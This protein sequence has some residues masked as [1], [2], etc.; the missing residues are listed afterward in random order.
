MT[1]VYFSRAMFAVLLLGFSSG[2]PL[3]L[4]T[5]TLQAW[6][7]EAGCDLT[8]IGL[9]TL[10]GLPYSIKVLWAPLLDRWG[11]ARLGRR[12]TWMLATQAGLVLG[13]L[14]MSRWTPS[15]PLLLLAC[16]ALFVALCSATQD[17]AL[18]AW[19]IDVLAPAELG[20]GASLAILG[21][22]CAVLT[23]FAGALR[24]AEM[25]SWNQVYALMA[26]A[27][28]VGFAATWLA[29][30]RREPDTRPTTLV[31][32]IWLPL[33]DFARRFGWR[34]GAIAAFVVLY[35]WGD[36]LAGNMSTSFL[37]EHGYK[38]GDIGD[39]QGGLGLAA[40][41][42][43]TLLGGWAFSRWSLA[44]CLWSFGLLQAA[45][46]LAYW[47][48]ALVPATWNGLAA[49]VTVENL[50]AGLGTAAFVGFLMALCDRRSSAV[51]Y[52]LLS[53]LMAA[54]RDL[55]AAPAGWVA[56]HLGWSGF[57]LATAVAAIPGLLLIPLVAGRRHQ[58]T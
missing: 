14:A 31:E 37:L 22:R 51:Q 30:C 52:A 13:L 47:G 29:G 20:A 24:L 35:K 4:V 2:L 33:V 6:M 57:F 49:A 39:L 45:T 44:A 9:A 23:S 21:Y 8:T 43:G 16:A 34:A 27:Q 26:V 19:R 55:L 5:K 1:F 11:W 32:A 54:G 56:Q 38:K 58:R 41:I 36:A 46:N 17:V 3:M 50:A 12:R 25:L 15:D 53:G 10:V 42:A 7:T 40:T 28:M 18:D 48:L